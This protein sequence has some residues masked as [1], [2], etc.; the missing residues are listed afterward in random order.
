MHRPRLFFI[1]SLLML[2]V[3]GL[4]LLT[5]C[6]KLL[7][8]GTPTNK[9]ITAQVYSNDSLAQAALIGVYFENDGGFWA[10]LMVI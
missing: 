8:A 10:R 5:G 4:P 7:D 9:V 3:A 2:T 1:L 6:N